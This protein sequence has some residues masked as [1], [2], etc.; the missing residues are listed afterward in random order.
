M[1]SKK[2]FILK[3]KKI[4]GILTTFCYK[5]SQIRWPQLPYLPLRHV[6]SLYTKEPYPQVGTLQCG[7]AGSLSRV[8]PSETWLLEQPSSTMHYGPAKTLLHHI[9]P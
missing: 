7:F 8:S 9:A 3:K 5:S 2:S 1:C 6:F 4:Q